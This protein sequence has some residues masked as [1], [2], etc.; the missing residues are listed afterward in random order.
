MTRNAL[1]AQGGRECVGA[2][3]RLEW[4]TDG[5]AG[6][7]DILYLDD[8]AGGKLGEYR[9]TEQLRKGRVNSRDN[10][11]T[12]VEIFRV[13][14]N[15]IHFYTRSPGSYLSLGGFAGGFADSEVYADAEV[16]EQ[17][18]FLTGAR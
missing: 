2:D 4:K 7:G 14:K 8:F 17:N 15:G 5:P 3:R 1:I 13:L 10:T 18:K 12:R 6:N 11:S 16:T 9:V